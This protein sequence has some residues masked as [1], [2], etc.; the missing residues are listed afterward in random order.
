MCVDRFA[1]CVLFECGNIYTYR[2][3][4]WQ[5]HYGVR[6]LHLQHRHVF[7]PFDI[8]FMPATLNAYSLH[9][10]IY[11]RCGVCLSIDVVVC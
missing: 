10:P 7:R 6:V 11:D 1:V 3:H 5:M 4:V 2:L 8:R 9:L